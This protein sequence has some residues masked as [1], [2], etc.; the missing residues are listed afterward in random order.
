M[1]IA[2][3]TLLAPVAAAAAASKAAATSQPAELADEDAC[4]FCLDKPASIIF[5]PCNHQVMC[6]AC[7]KLIVQRKQPCPMCRTPVSSMQTLHEIPSQSA[8]D[9]LQERR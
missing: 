3:E 9:P 6:P 7:A 5:H 2:K 1:R 4:V 8:L